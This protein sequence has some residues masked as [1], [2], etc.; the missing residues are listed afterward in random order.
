MVISDGVT[1]ENW[2]ITNPLDLTQKTH[3]MS[4]EHGGGH[5]RVDECEENHREESATYGFDS[6]GAMDLSSNASSSVKA[7]SDDDNDMISDSKEE[8]RKRKADEE[9]PMMIRRKKEK[10]EDDQLESMSGSGQPSQGSTKNK[11]KNIREVLEEENLNISTK[12]CKSR[13]GGKVDKVERTKE[14]VDDGSVTNNKTS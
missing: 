8:N 2:R 1:S 10:K 9:L 6:Y 3:K 4:N 14:N 13:R 12:N 5:S 7:Q 11:R